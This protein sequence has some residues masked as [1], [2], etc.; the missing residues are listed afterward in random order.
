M[1]LKW[2][3][4]EITEF[5]NRISNAGKFN[6]YISKSVKEIAKKLHQM[7]IT[8]TPVDFGTLQAFWKTSENYSYIVE[9]SKNGFEVTLINRAIYATWVNDGHKQRPGRFIPGRWEGTH[10]RYDPNA[11]SG[12]VLK[13]SW[14]QGRFFVEKSILQLENS[15]GIEQ[16][17]YKQ[18]DKWFGW[19][20]NGK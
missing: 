10:F 2:D 14:V 13:N 18:L 11:D 12:M 16:I 19:C 8:N 5:G 3:V 15:V 1:K 6:E 20:V 9:Q 17:V 7:L 4:H